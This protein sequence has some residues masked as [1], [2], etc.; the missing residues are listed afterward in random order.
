MTRENTYIVPVKWLCTGHYLV[1]AKDKNELKEKLEK[2]SNIA[3]C[4]FEDDEDLFN[5]TLSFDYDDIDE[6][7]TI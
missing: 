7:T 6:L 5:E 3:N 2:M 1:N 4:P